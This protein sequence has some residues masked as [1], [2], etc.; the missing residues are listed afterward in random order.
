VENTSS[1]KTKNIYIKKTYVHGPFTSIAANNVYINAGCFAADSIRYWFLYQQNSQELNS[2][3]NQIQAQQIALDA[4]SRELDDLRRQI[5]EA[6]NEAKK[7]GEEAAEL[8]GKL[9]VAVIKKPTKKPVV[10]AAK[11]RVHTEESG[12]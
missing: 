5:K 10:K 8:R 9:A 6:R 3:R 12:T 7:A 11:I 4:A 1:T 2:S